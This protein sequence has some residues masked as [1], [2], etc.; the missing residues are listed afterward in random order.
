MMCSSLSAIQVKWLSLERQKT[1]AF[2]HDI[3]VGLYRRQKLWKSWNGGLQAFALR[4]RRAKK[5]FNLS[6]SK[7]FSS[8]ARAERRHR[9]AIKKGRTNI[10]KEEWTT[11]IDIVPSDVAFKAGMAMV[12]MFID[13]YMIDGSKISGSRNDNR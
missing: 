4:R 5:S 8:E 3:L 2:G 10:G 9:N 1:C 7:G 6:H 13:S 11:Q 12:R